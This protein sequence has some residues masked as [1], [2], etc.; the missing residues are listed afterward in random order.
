[1]TVA[2]KCLFCEDTYT[3]QDLVEL[4]ELGEKYHLE[5]ILFICSDCYDDLQRLPLE[6]QAKALLQGADYDWTK[7]SDGEK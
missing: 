4:D 6:E 2:Y 7:E 5:S 1:M 3:E